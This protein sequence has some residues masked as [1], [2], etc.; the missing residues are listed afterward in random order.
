MSEYSEDDPD[1]QAAFNS[2]LPEQVH[3]VEIG[4]TWTPT[5]NFMT[6][7]QFTIENSWQKSQ[8]ANFTENDYPIVWTVWYAPTYRW[9]FTGGYAYYSNW[10]DQDIT[11]GTNRGDPMPRPP[12]RNGTMP[13]R[14][15]RFS[16][17]ASYAW[18]DNA[19][20]SWADTSGI[21]EVIPSRLIPS[22]RAPTG[23]CCPLCRTCSWKRSVSRPVSI[24][25]PTR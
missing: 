20:N 5:D 11:L 17:N 23:R 18:T 1:S 14:T 12:R 25:N 10:I 9:S 19:C 4:G 16:L 15:I 7:A 6:T 22:R 2:S 24:G 3:S 8:Y 13:E 21:E